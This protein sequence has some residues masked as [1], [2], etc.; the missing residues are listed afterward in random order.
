LHNTSEGRFIQDTPRIVDTINNVFETRNTPH[1][2]LRLAY[3]R[4]ND[5]E[6]MTFMGVSPTFVVIESV[7][8]PPFDSILAP[9]LGAC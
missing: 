3:V 7:V 4:F 2:W 6:A 8:E 5:M 9:G 1:L